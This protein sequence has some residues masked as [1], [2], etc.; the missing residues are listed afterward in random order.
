MLL[1]GRLSTASMGTSALLLEI[2]HSLIVLLLP[3]ADTQLPLTAV[4]WGGLHL[5]PG[6]LEK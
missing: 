6:I 1:M 5:L 2:F 3:A 4:S